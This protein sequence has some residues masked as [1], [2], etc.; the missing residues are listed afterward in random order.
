MQDAPS[1]L[2][3]LLAFAAVIALIPIA[4]WVLKRLQSGPVGAPRAVTL[5]GG[6][7]LGPRERIVIVE[8]EGRRWLV[9]VTAQS[10]GLLAELERSEAATTDTAAAGA[11][12]GSPAATPRPGFPPNPFA[13]ML[14]KFKRHG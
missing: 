14:D 13:T 5:A 3:A 9:G 10:I 6:L 8:A 2:P 1:V 12:G 11:A 7:S 4:L